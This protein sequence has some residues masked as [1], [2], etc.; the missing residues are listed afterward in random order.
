[1]VRSRSQLGVRA[2]RGC[3]VRSPACV[4]IGA[5]PCFYAGDC[6]PCPEPGRLRSSRSARLGCRSAQPAPRQPLRS[7]RRAP[8]PRALHASGLGIVAGPPGPG[9]PQHLAREPPPGSRPARAFDRLRARGARD[10]RADSQAD[11]R[12]GTQPSGRQR[13][14]SRRPRGNLPRSAFRPRRHDA[15]PRHK[16]SFRPGALSR[17]SLPLALPG[18]P[19]LVPALLAAPAASKPRRCRPV[20]GHVTRTGAQELGTR[21]C[22][23]HTIDATID[24]GSPTDPRGRRQSCGARSGTVSAASSLRA[25]RFSGCVA[26]PHRAA[27]GLAFSA[28]SDGAP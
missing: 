28:S 8:G 1:M 5:D 9:R 24:H 11:S 25:G 3:H 2:P 4:A 23:C 26:C 27:G 17:C 10:G 19:W 7:R 6:I 21:R 22:S 13:R 14:L 12:S 16:R 18:S 15:H 20:P